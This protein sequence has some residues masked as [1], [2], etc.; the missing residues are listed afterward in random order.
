MRGR[1]PGPDRL[2]GAAGCSGGRANLSRCAVVRPH[3]YGRGRSWRTRR[4]CRPDS[5]A[6][7]AGTAWPG[8]SASG[9]WRP[10]RCRRADGPCG[11]AAA[12]RPARTP[13]TR[14][15]RRPPPP[16]GLRPCR[17]PPSLS[18][19]H[20][21]QSS[22]VRKR[23]KADRHRFAGPTGGTERLTPRYEPSPRLI[24][25]HTWL[26][27]RVRRSL[28]SFPEPSMITPTSVRNRAADAPAPASAPA[29]VGRRP[30]RGARWRRVGLGSSPSPR[31]SR[32]ASW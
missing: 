9:P 27:A 17:H 19:F 25:P 16:L 3:T 23:L 29:L 14:R 28:P 30:E 26:S 11:K 5:P 10:P 18:S 22:R 2:E 24:C 31:F 15:S 21:F 13:R 32:S 6:A 7:S 4:G 12:A 8:W 20:P 1:H